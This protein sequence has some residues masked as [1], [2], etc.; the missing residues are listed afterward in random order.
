MSFWCKSALSNVV[1]AVC[2]TMHKGVF[3][4]FGVTNSSSLQRTANTFGRRF[5]MPYVTVSAPSY[6]WDPTRHAFT[7]FLRPEYHKA[8]LN[9]VQHHQ[10]P[11][12]YYIYN[13]NDGRTCSA[14]D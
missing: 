2:S 5:Q 3:A 8:V 13:T 4:F 11:K 9:I 14:I 12:G 6:D 7:L 10:W 1:S